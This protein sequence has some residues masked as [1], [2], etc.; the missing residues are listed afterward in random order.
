MKIKDIFKAIE[1]YK[2][3]TK[4]HINNN[5]KN[6]FVQY[7]SYQKPINNTKLIAFYL[8]QFHQIEENNLWHGRGFTEWTNVTKAIPHFEGHLQPHLPYD[9][10]FYD[11]S[12]D[13]VMYRQV[14]LAKN[15]GIAGFC[16]H[17]YW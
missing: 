15:Y 8:P 10:G 3:I 14:E 2:Y 16:F 12:H 9:V 17:Y 6:D 4:L 13:S 1:L 5:K 7:K 11:L